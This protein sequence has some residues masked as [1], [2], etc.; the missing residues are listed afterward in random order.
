MSIV[1]LRLPEVK[2]KT[3]ERPKKCRY[4]DGDK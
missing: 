1:I 4:C 3:E 2:R